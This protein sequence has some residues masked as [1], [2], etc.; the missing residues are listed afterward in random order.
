MAAIGGGELG[1]GL[2]EGWTEGV[3]SVVAD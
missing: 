3:D 1:G 2:A